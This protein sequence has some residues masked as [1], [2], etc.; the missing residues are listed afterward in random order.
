MKIQMANLR[1]ILEKIEHRGSPYVG[2]CTFMAPDNTEDTRITFHADFSLLMN[3]R[4][5]DLEDRVNRLTEENKELK[6]K[7]ENER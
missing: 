3:G 7:L 1:H 4:I 6:R 2:D 5:R